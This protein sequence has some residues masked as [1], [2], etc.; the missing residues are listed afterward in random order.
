MLKCKA[1]RCFCRP[2]V[3][4]LL[5]LLLLQVSRL[6]AAGCSTRHSPFSSVLAD[7]TT[8]RMSDL[9]DVI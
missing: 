3:A 7:G 8:L 9:I 1:E 6:P 4:S 5:L 2:W